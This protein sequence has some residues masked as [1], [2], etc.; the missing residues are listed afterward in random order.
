MFKKI[1]QLTVVLVTLTICVGL[2]L[3][4]AGEE[5]GKDQGVQKTLTNDNY[6]F[7]TI[8]NLFNWYGNNGNSSYNIATANSG[9]EFPKGSGNAPVFEDGLLWGGYHKGRTEP[10]VGGSAYR[11]GLQ[12]G[13][14]TGYGG[15]LEADRP[16]SADPTLAKYRVYKV[17]PDVTPTTV[18]ADVRDKME[19]EAALVNRYQ[20]L[21]G[22][23]LFANYQKDW[24]E[25]PA[26][27][28]L[29]APY[30]DVNGNGVYDPA[31]DVPG[32][33]G[34]DQT[35]YYVAN[36]L[37]ASRTTN[38]YFSPPIGLEVHRTVWGYNLPGALGNT[39]FAST[40]II[41]KSGAALDSAFLV[42]FSDPDLGESGD[43]YCGCDVDRS[44]GFIYNGKNVD[45]VY[46]SEVPA[47][48]YD[49]F[50]GPIVATGNNSDSAVF[51]LKYRKGYKNLG[52]TTFDFFINSSA[53]YTDPPQGV[54]GGDVQWYRLMNAAVTTTGAPFI[55]P[56]TGAP[57]KFCLSGDPLTGKG[58]LDGTHGLTPGDRRIC[59]VTGPFTLANKD[60]QE[61]VTA[62]IVGQGKDRISSIAVLKFYSDLAQSAYNTLFNISR[63][64]PSP[65]IEV[66]A[67]DGEV[68]IAWPDTVGPIK[69]ETWNSGG[70]QFEG[71]NVYQ[72]PSSAGDV[73]KAVRLATYDLVDAITTIFDD[74]FDEGTGYV[75]SKPAQ[76]G[77]DFGIKRSYT[78]KNDAIGKR[79]LINGST[80]YFGVTSYS[81]NSL[82]TAKPAQLE[83]SPNLKAVVPQ[84]SSPGVRYF[85]ASGDTLKDVVHTGPSD[86]Q[87]IA[88]VINPL[89]LKKEGATY[90]V[91]FNGT[92]PNQTWNIVRT[93]NGAVDT[94][95]K[96]M[97]DQAATDAGA[98][99]VDGIDFRVIGAPN[100]FKYFFTVS[101]AS[102]AITPFQQGAF[103]FNSSGFPL[104]PEGAD[105]PTQAQQ[106]AGKLNASQGWG[107]HT[108]M[109]SPTMS[110]SYTNFKSRVTNADAR[111]PVIIPYD[112]EIRFTAAGGK[113]LIPSA[114]T[115][116]AD[117][118]VDVPFEL[119]NIGINTPTNTADDYRMYPYILDVDNSASFNLLTKAG[120]DSV[121]NGGGGSTHSIS[122]GSNDPFTD[123]IYW[124]AP[125]NK[126]PGHAGYD[127]VAAAE[128]AA[129]TGGTDPY[130][131]PT[132][133][134]SG[135]IIR[136]L[137]LVG[138]NMGAVATGPG[139]YKMTMP[140]AGTTFR[141]ISTKPNQ[142]TDQFVL[143][144]APAAQNSTLAEADA[145]RVNVFP[146]PYI[147][148]N[149]QEANKYQRF[150]TFTHMPRAAT[151]R[152][153][154]LAGVLVRTM[155][156]DD[157]TQF[158][159]WDLRNES[160]FPVAAGMYIVHIDMPDVGK[161]KV[162]KLGVI[163]E[164]QFID[165][166]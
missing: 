137:V 68:A 153:F 115:G 69:I 65:S 148:F 19:A 87:L 95:A 119:W 10:K 96:R 105:R 122:G 102:G 85:A 64:P 162:L 103:A 149:A 56:T 8:N 7:F 59:L 11:Y 12:A 83:S 60:T 98:A 120:T 89:A 111:W 78:T 99:I 66:A 88:Q 129:V 50:Q 117:Y 145:D 79:T 110:L 86:G 92:T 5:K 58:W 42:Q 63:P 164:Q 26:K 158:F 39:I 52:M 127:A 41:N 49:F 51:R 2:S 70:Y 14:V 46:G 106:S 55:D 30:K 29:P 136:R 147:G 31:V 6:N 114:F 156:K 44:L 72:F 37:N 166:W 104:T 163:P 123:W 71:Y 157:A 20:T 43:D 91:V 54:A 62:T 134:A 21:S 124:V 126:A 100:D 45:N 140:E 67:L 141:I 139:S 121:D 142:P 82:P 84:W 107:I 77:T 97:T 130:L 81:F 154:N 36:D 113:A 93:W 47:A 135:D 24:N 152:I 53:I 138:W 13:E 73:S 94:V 15:P 17:R 150:V 151:L 132:I 109:N 116:V 28:G 48:G 131:S 32:Q 35:L 16:P 1:L 3:A 90:K 155:Q 18:Y 159:Q 27:D 133:P 4:L 57:T 22:P 34:A 112:F 118:I 108:G 161:V 75:V 160:G 144:V 23:T 101:N 74:Q 146:N 40:I 33:V 80:Y 9:L 38:M 76:Y 25:W 143:T 128:Q 125:T 61:V 165:K